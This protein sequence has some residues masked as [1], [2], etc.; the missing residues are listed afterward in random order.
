MY[1]K[2]KRLKKQLCDVDIPLEE[3][4]IYIIFSKIFE[5][6]DNEVSLKL[7]ET[8]DSI[9]SKNILLSYFQEKKY[10]IKDLNH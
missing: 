9:E 5:H 10:E 3:F 4:E 2:R 6:L 8:D 7:I 1:F